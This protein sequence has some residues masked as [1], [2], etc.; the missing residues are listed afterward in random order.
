MYTP[1]DTIDPPVFLITTRLLPP[2]AVE[3]ETVPDVSAG[4]IATWVSRA[5]LDRD[6]PLVTVA[7]SKFGCTANLILHQTHS[8]ILHLLHTSQAP[9][10]PVFGLQT[11]RTVNK[12]ANTTH[13]G[14]P[15][16]NNNLPSNADSTMLFD[17]PNLGAPIVGGCVG[18]NECVVQSVEETA[19]NWVVVAECVSGGRGNG[20]GGDERCLYL[21]EARRV[22]DK[23]VV[24]QL[25]WQFLRDTE[26]DTLIRRVA[27]G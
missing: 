23:E 14:R 12:F 1:L 2:N 18:W 9:L 8:F 6:R 15:D 24:K 26:R 10:I 11:S 19:T 4:Q 25:D 17:S 7:F 3:G 27:R 20:K 16:S 13:C 5:S 22:L 21:G